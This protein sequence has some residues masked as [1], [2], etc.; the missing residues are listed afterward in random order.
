METLELVPASSRSPRWYGV[1]LVIASLWLLWTLV[2]AWVPPTV[3]PTLAAA[4]LFSLER[5]L[6]RAQVGVRRGVDEQPC[7]W[8]ATER[9]FRCGGESFAFV[10]P[11]AGWARGA[12]QACTWLH[13]L[14][15]GATTVLRWTDVPWRGQLQVELS[16]LDDVGP[17]AE[18][19]LRLWA[20]EQ[21]LGD[22]QV[23]SGREVGVLTQSLQLPQ[24]GHGPLRLEVTAHDHG[25]RLACAQVRL[26]PESR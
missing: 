2:S 20:G 13:P 8:S 19:H 22:V 9:S 6:P 14:P 3:N 4:P 25:W 21:A 7:A 16:L 12:S 5:D 10:G 18:V 26:M 23:A 17:G 1:W 24:G 15:G 11:Y